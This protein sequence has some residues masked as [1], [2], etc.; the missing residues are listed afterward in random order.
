MPPAQPAIDIPRFHLTET[1]PLTQLLGKPVERSQPHSLEALGQGHGLMLYRHKVVHGGKGRLTFGEVRDYALVT[2]GGRTIASLDRRLKETGC[3]VDLHKGRTL[4]VL[5]DTMGHINYGEW[6]G[7]DQKGLI[8]AVTLNDAPVTGWQ[9]YALPLDDLSGLRFGTA[10]ADGPAFHRGVFDL[11]ETGYCFLD[12]RGWGKGYVWVN[13]FNLG[14]HWS[15]GPQRAL[16]VPQSV[17]KTGRNEVI[18]L[19]LHPGPQTTLAGGQHQIWDL[20]GLA[21]Q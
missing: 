2:V 16:Y 13:G 12:V 20:P 7:K 9:H 11:A 14:R 15:V 8:G 4:D 10:P 19:D 21:Q 1:A 6:I 5:V 18:V 3:D 17:L